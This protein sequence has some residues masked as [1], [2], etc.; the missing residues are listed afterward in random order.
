MNLT[1]SSVTSIHT[2]EEFSGAFRMSR[3][4]FTNL[5][6]VIRSAIR[7]NGEMGRRSNRTAIMA[8][9]SLGISL[10]LLAGAD[11]WDL[12]SSYHVRRSTIH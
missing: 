8:D 11:M 9:M 2:G 3:P 12:I 4:I 6:R 7:K 1:F 5:L 10:R